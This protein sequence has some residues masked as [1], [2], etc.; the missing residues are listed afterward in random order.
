MQLELRVDAI[1]NFMNDGVDSFKYGEKKG[2]LI[3]K[4]MIFRQQLKN[5]R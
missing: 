4:N 3:Y 1:K 2:S 5:D